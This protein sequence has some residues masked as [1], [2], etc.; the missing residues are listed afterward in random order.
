MHNHGN[1]GRKC[2]HDEPCL[3]YLLSSIWHASKIVHTY[4]IPKNIIHLK[5]IFSKGNQSSIKSATPARKYVRN[6]PY[7]V[8]VDSISGMA[9]EGLKIFFEVNSL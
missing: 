4:T 3:V 2:L 5:D 6:S 7:A 9:Q 8:L 1:K